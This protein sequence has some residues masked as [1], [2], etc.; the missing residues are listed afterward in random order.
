MSNKY[1]EEL[2]FPYYINQSRLLDL[3]AILNGGYTEYEEINA[4]SEA[5]NKK[6][7]SAKVEG[8]GFKIFRIGGGLSGTIEGGSNEASSSSTKI[9]QTTTSMLGIVISALNDRGYVRD[10]A[11]ANAGSFII[12]PVVLKINSIK[13]LINEAKA[14]LEL[15]EKMQAVGTKTSGK[16]KSETLEQVKQIA[17]V[18]RELFGAE[19]I[20]CETDS[21]ALV[22]TI[23]D[24]HL[25]QAV[26][27]D[28]IR[29]ELR[30]LAQVKR[31]FPEG[32]QLMKNTI[33]TKIR[34]TSSKKALIESMRALSD[35]G[36]FEY[37]CDAIPEIVDKPVYQLEIVALYQS[38]VPHNSSN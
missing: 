14:L 33:F 34:D 9:V 31:V 27:A 1:A 17:G 3:Y 36:N 22:G 10:I 28:I 25:Y 18:C 8:S 32:T 11:S 26:R 23:S 35:N 6:S 16:T 38:S 4:S 30:C 15:S 13:S 2:F 21:Y 24:E 5:T 19:E 7:G 37:E 12:V 20:I 29:T